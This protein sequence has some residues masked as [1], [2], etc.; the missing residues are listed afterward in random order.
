VLSGSFWFLFLY[1][2][3]E[4]IDLDRLRRLLGSSSTREPNFPRAAPE[5]VRFERPPV[6]EKSEPATF[7]G[8]TLEGEVT[9]YDYG[10]IG[11]RL[12]LPFTCDWPQLVDRSSRLLNAHEPEMQAAA[13]V[14]KHLERVRDALIK[15]HDKPHENWLNE[16]YLVIHLDRSP[17]AGTCDELFRQH[18]SDIAKIVRGE[19]TELAEAEKEEILRSR[20][21]YY[22]D[23]L[24]VAGWAAAF[25]YDSREGAAP[26]LQLLE[27]ANTQLLEFRYYDRLLTRVLEDVYRSL[28]ARGGFWARWKMARQARR[29]NTIRLEVHEL[30]ERA[31]TAIK[32][33]S[34][35]FSARLY[36]LAAERVGVDDYRRLVDNK[37]HTGANLYEFMMDQFHQGRAFVLEVIVVIILLID[38]AFL[39]R[40]RR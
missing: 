33:L 4:A 26:A 2:V 31:D 35:M 10:V 22:P 37:L 7:D 19:S 5:Y 21:S 1:D 39:F 18:G 16:D 40:G 6:A 9:Y 23:D 38:L 14:R 8:E 13:I 24:L 12:E 11:V 32:F 29:L 25:I 20:M 28:D 36:R 3:G 17:G 27:Y 30:T 15:P 34:D